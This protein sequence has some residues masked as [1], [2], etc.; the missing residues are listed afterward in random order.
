M[1]S[2]FAFRGGDAACQAL[3]RADDDEGH[4]LRN[5]PDCTSVGDA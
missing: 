5:A 2:L 1:P 4:R 3:R